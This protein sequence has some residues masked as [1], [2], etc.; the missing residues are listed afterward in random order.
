M[1]VVWLC[2]RVAD[3]APNAACAFFGAI[4]GHRARHRFLGRLA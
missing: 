3:S 1:K 4:E 2:H